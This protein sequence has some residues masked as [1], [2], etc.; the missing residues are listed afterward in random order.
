MLELAMRGRL[1]DQLA[2]VGIADAQIIAAQCVPNRSA[3]EKRYLSELVNWA[4]N[5]L[6]PVDGQVPY[7]GI[8]CAL[9]GLEFYRLELSTAHFMYQYDRALIR[10]FALIDYPT[11]DLLITSE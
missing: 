2:F 4:D 8:R 9:D 1:K 3:Y 10:V 6:N 7:L 11:P 5:L